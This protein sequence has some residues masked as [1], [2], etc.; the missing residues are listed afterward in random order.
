[1]GS[2][3]VSVII[4]TYNSG[5][6]VADAVESVLA[7]TLPP[8]EILVID[9]GSVDDTPQR[10]TNYCD[11]ITYIR[12][13]NQGVAAARNCGI[14]ASREEFVAFLDADDVWHPQKLE[15]QLQVMSRRPELSLLG[16]QCFDW[17]APRFEDVGDATA[18]PVTIVPWDRQVVVNRLSTSSN[19][20]RRRVFEKVGYFDTDLQG[21]EDH[22]LFTRIAEVYLTANLELPLTG[23]RNVPASL[24]KQAAR[25]ESGMRQILTKLDERNAWGKRWLLRRKAQSYVDHSCGYMYGAA[26]CYRRAILHSI[27]SLVRYP[28]PYAR[29]EVHTSLERPKRLALLVLRALRL[30]R[31]ECDSQV[32][33]L[34]QAASVS[35]AVA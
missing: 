7:Q 19:L 8:A 25:M 35:K 14:R 15:R 22:D 26:G 31:P 27:R 10:L 2:A 30:S 1:M 17:P 3:P 11:R 18:N 23:Y 9:D 24:S 12:Q 33:P 6:L 32:S 28:L 21:P 29:D 34:E 20:V 16:T 13:Q 4:P 5:R